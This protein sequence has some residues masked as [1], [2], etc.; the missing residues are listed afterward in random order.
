[1]VEARFP[2]DSPDVNPL[3]ATPLLLFF[4]LAIGQPLRP[5][6]HRT[7]TW[8][9]WRVTMA[10]HR[11]KSRLVAGIG[12]GEKGRQMPLPKTVFRLLDSGQRLIIGAFAHH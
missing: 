2:P 12:I 10:E 4:H 11:Q 5:A 9:L 6:D 7:T 8:P 1:M 3:N